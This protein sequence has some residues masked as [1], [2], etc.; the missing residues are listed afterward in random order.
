MTYIPPDLPHVQWSDE[1]LFDEVDWIAT[2]RTEIRP[3]GER[4]IDLKRRMGR[5]T[6]EQMIR[7]NETHA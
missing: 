2:H 6:M 5:A 3:T 4:D 1:Q 7:Y